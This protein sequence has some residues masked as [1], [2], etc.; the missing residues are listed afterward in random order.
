MEEAVNEQQ[1]RRQRSALA[2]QLRS[3]RRAL[4]LVWRAAPRWT[5]AWFGLLLLQGVLPVAIVYLTRAV[6]DSVVEVLGVG[7]SWSSIR[8]VLLPAA[9]MGGVLVLG[10]LLA[11]LT[12][13]V[14]TGQVEEVRDHVTELIQTKSAAVDL[15]F[16]ESSDFYDHLHRAR[17]HAIERP[18]ALV[19]GLGGLLQNSVTLL[20]MGAVLVPFGVWLPLALLASTVPALYVVVRHGL[21]RH[22]W[23]VGTTPERRRAD[24]YDGLLTWE[25]SAAELRLFGLAGLFRDRFRSARSRL[26]KERL[27]LEKRRAWAETGAGFFALLVT[28]AAVAWMLWQAARGTVTLGDLALFYQAFTQ[29]QRLL[30]SLLQQV[31]QV[32][33]DSLL[34]DDLFAFLA[35]E[36]TLVDGPR[37]SPRRH[38]IEEGIR[39]ES[40]TFRYPGRSSP[41]LE[42]C[43]LHLPAGV[44][45]SV[46]GSNGAGKSTLLK[47]LC[48]FYDP[49]QGRILIDGVDL[50][51]YSLEDARRF[52]SALFQEPVHYNES[53]TDNIV[54]SDPAAAAL[55]GQGAE[56]VREA[57]AH[58]EAKSLVEGLSSGYETA[59]G[60]WF[61]NG[62]ELS[63]GEWQRIA[64]ARAYY[65]PAP[66]LLLDEPTSAMD[67]WAETAWMKR[68]RRSVVD[69]TTL[70]VTHRLTT[71]RRTDL[72]LVMAEGRVVEQGTHEELVASAG[73]YAQSWLEQ[74]AHRADR[75]DLPAHS[76]ARSSG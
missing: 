37:P 71:A 60:R 8:P 24:Y 31:G 40:V 73:S 63:V 62:I 9:G 15:G 59:L 43:D 34:L 19:E 23:T 28:A 67:A 27:A 5:L 38:R 3:L 69:R 13:W 22:A 16:Y 45:A 11:G 55:P 70:L 26:R 10:E 75:P 18:Q 35:L 17:D 4:A 1:T 51:E 39:F 14:R 56:R 41:A 36:S 74:T 33:S 32:Y 47:L 53:V 29:G 65:R 49:D 61:A 57:A 48:R 42:D 50:R 12:S 52:V 7:A 68:L 64:L 25:E 2:G 54:F 44:L 20:A 46:V 58:A 72:V 30:R 6:V 66:L 21:R 76:D